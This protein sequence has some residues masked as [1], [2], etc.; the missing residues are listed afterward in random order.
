MIITHY[1]P[2]RPH[3]PSPRFHA[4]ERKSDMHG[5]NAK[6]YPWIKI[7]NAPIIVCVITSGYLDTI[8]SGEFAMD[9]SY[10]CL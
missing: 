2:E 4:S 5:E 8:D 10:R 7:D 1:G 3:S 6:K 9:I